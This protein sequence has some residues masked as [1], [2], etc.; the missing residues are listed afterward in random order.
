[1]IH[2]YMTKYVNEH[3]QFIVESWI[4]I[5]VF[6]RC[7]TISDRKIVLKKPSEDGQNNSEA[8]NTR[9]VIFE[10]LALKGPAV[11]REEYLSHYDEYVRRCSR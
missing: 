3:G 9:P 5:N 2:H 11:S 10:G 1:M 7:Y 6:R 8:V 4:Q